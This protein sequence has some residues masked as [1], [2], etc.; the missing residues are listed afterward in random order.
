[1]PEKVTHSPSGSPTNREHFS[2][3]D[4]NPEDTFAGKP[5]EVLRCPKAEPRLKRVADWAKRTPL[6]YPCDITDRLA[7]E[8]RNLMILFKWILKELRT[9]KDAIGLLGRTVTPWEEVVIRDDPEIDEAASAFDKT[10]EDSQ[11]E[12]VVEDP[13][14]EKEMQFAR[15]TSN[16]GKMARRRRT[17]M[18][19][20]K[21]TQQLGEETLEESIRGPPKRATTSLAGSLRESLLGPLTPQQEDK[22][23]E[24]PN[25][26]QLQ[27]QQ[28]QPEF[29]G[30]EEVSSRRQTRISVD[31]DEY[32]AA[33]ETHDPPGGSAKQSRAFNAAI[34]T[35]S[36]LADNVVQGR[37]SSTVLDAHTSQASVEP[38]SHKTTPANKV[39]DETK[40]EVAAFD[41]VSLT[42]MVRTT[43]TVDRHETVIQDLQKA[44]EIMKQR[45]DADILE[46][47]SLDQEQRRPPHE[48]EELL[49]ADPRYDSVFVRRDVFQE[50]QRVI[51]MMRTEFDTWRTETDET[52]RSHTDSLRQVQRLDR[53]CKTLFEQS[54]NISSAVQKLQE[55]VQGAQFK[56]LMQML[57]GTNKK[58][59]DVETFRDLK[60]KV[61]VLEAGVNEVRPA[62]QSL[63]KAFR[64][65]DQ[66][67]RIVNRQVAASSRAENRRQ[68]DTVAWHTE[69]SMEW[70]EKKYGLLYEMCRSLVFSE[71]PSAQI[72]D[73]LAAGN[74]ADTVSYPSDQR[75]CLSCNRPY[76]YKRFKQLVSEVEKLPARPQITAAVHT[77]PQTK[78]VHPAMGDPDLHHNGY[79][80]SFNTT[81]AHNNS[82]ETST[83]SFDDL[84]HPRPST[85]GS[86]WVVDGNHQYFMDSHGSGLSGLLRQNNVPGSP[87]P[88]PRPRSSP[89]GR[90]SS[91]PAQIAALQRA[92]AVGQK[93]R[94]ES[95]QVSTAN[96]LARDL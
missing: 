46:R 71:L 10:V 66:D 55:V 78:Q 33:V 95:Q 1:M 13:Q 32:E 48:R 52:L 96:R 51:S 91:K 62:M 86:N 60:H 81:N 88:S 8:P 79:H 67:P 29:P 54:Q 9:Q 24:T 77:M 44:V 16:E 4:E 89:P 53:Q 80:Q 85:P 28:Q 19:G 34:H 39:V 40:A 94:R 72:R 50:T 36:D 27:D 73:G 63:Q 56:E 70:L 47:I 37:S 20:P 43:G 76:D 68:I 5:L 57:T 82:Q 90:K 35:L 3:N 42:W 14:K 83:F 61:D 15:R 23:I 21:P 92:S 58:I 12:I 2:S 17:T 74:V 64:D 18:C 69:T 87:Q 6:D 25:E 59:V 31:V 93:K 41:A 45:V 22:E 38:T 49:A 84:G 11:K 30:Q 26:A 75:T 7:K 65:I